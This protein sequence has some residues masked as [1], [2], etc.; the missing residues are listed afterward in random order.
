MALSEKKERFQTRMPS[1]VLEQLTQAASLVGATLNQFM[2]QASL[3]KAQHL[4]ERE[5]SMNLSARDAKV[6]FDALENPPLPGE[7]L[8]EAAEAYNLEFPND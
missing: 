1:N 8:K 5:Q 2:V 4:L 3:E 7:K 6:F